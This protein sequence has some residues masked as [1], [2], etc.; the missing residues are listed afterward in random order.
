MMLH[1]LATVVPQLLLA[2]EEEGKA[3]EPGITGGP[4]VEFAWLIVVVP[5]LT[6]FLI[7]LFGKKSPFKGWLMAELAIGFVA[8]Y[9]TVLFILNATEG[10]TYYGQIEIAEIGSYTLEWGVAVDGLSHLLHFVHGLKGR[11]N[12]RIT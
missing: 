6:T 1:A 7:V 8:V 4:I 3:I 9:G 11:T 2:A 10:V 5:I 12:G